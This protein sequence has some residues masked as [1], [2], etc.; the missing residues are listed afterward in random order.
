MPE[1]ISFP[2]G[3]PLWQ[4][5]IIRLLGDLVLGYGVLC[6][7]QEASRLVGQYHH[8]RCLVWALSITWALSA[9]GSRYHKLKEM[10]LEEVFPFLLGW[11]QYMG[12]KCSLTIPLLLPSEIYLF[13]W[14]QEVAL[15]LVVVLPVLR[16]IIKSSSTYWF[17][18]GS[19]VNS[20]KMV[21]LPQLWNTCQAFSF[22]PE[23]PFKTFWIISSAL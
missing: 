17:S 19:C 16:R 18:S 23:V 15:C 21:P 5:C 1:G 2:G 8:P 3:W 20:D 11:T 4:G 9:S 6:N 12:E 22:H 10:L 14:L 7:L 13:M